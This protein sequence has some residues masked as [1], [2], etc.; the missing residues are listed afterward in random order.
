[1]TRPPKFTIAAL[2]GV[3]AFCAATFAALRASSPYWA[4]A[5]VSTTVLV[6]LGSIVASLLGRHRARWS[7]FAIFGCGYFLLTFTSPFRDVV[8]PHLFT[9]VAIV[10]SYRHLHPEVQVDMTE[11]TP[12]QGA[13]VP[14]CRRRSPQRARSKCRRRSL[15]R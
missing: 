3:V 1:M 13:G 15:S 9:S 7:G 5:M 2:M 10:E 12:L 6:L 11:M 4:S 14:A 8:R